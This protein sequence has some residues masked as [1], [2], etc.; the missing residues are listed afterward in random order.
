MTPRINGTGM[1]EAEEWCCGVEDSITVESAPGISWS[2]CWSAASATSPGIRS[3]S[4]SKG[5][6]GEKGTGASEVDRTMSTAAV[7]DRVCGS[8]VVDKVSVRG[9]SVVVE[10][11]KAIVVDRTAGAFVVEVSLVVEVVDNI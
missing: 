7:V 9:T 5:I 10:R 2:T 8:A 11:G 3:A 6:D 1:A 4:E